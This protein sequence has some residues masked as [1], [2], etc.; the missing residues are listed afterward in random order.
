MR[1]EKGWEGRLQEESGKVEWT[2]NLANEETMVKQ[3]ARNVARRW[4][5]STEHPWG[6]KEAN[7]AR[8]DGNEEKLDEIIRKRKIMELQKISSENWIPNRVTLKLS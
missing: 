7:V 6:N 5:M 1:A 8:E 2:W 4:T 3:D